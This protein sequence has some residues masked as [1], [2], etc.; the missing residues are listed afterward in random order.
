MPKIPYA[1]VG[2][3][4]IMYYQPDPPGAL[5]PTNLGPTAD[6]IMPIYVD[7]YRTNEEIYASLISSLLSHARSHLK[8]ITRPPRLY[9]DYVH[10]LDQVIAGIGHTTD[11]PS[12]KLLCKQ[13]RSLR[14]RTAKRDNLARLNAA[15][16]YLQACKYAHA[17]SEGRFL[18][19]ATIAYDN[20][21]VIKR[22]NQ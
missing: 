16:A 22:F 11:R 5:K 18:R 21:Q 20:E 6:Y 14:T 2:Y 3:E 10:T 7:P 12:I 13:L 8:R 1:C 17:P 4:Y 15:H 9:A 19:Q